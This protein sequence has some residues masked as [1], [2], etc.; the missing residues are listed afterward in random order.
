[1]PLGTDTETIIIKPLS[2]L[3]TGAIFSEEIVVSFQLSYNATGGTFTITVLKDTVVLPPENAV[4]SMPF[5]RVGIVKN[6]GGGLSTGG[7]VD[8]ISGPILPLSATLVNFVGIPNGTNQ[9]AATLAAQL[10]G[11]SGVFWET[12]VPFVKNF[13]YRGISLPG[14]QQLAQIVLAD[15]IVRK[16]GIH[17]VDPG[18]VIGNTPFNVQKSDIVSASQVLDFSQDIASVL[19]PALVTVIINDQGD[20]VYDSQ[21]AQKQPKF[22]VQAGSPQSQAAKDFIPIPDGWLVDGNFE[23]WTPPSSTDFSNPSASVPAGR[24]WKVY[25][26]PV[27]PAA[28]RGITNFTRL[29]KEVKLPGNVSSFI[30]SPITGLTRKNTTLEFIF[31]NK[32]TESGI[33]GFNADETTMFD[34]ISHQF[35]TFD[36]ALVLRPNSGVDSSDASSNF[37]SITMEQWTFPR[38][39]PQIFPVGDPVNPFGLPTNVVV[40]TPSS[41]VIA[42]DLGS[43]HQKYLSNYRLINSPRLRTT[44]SVV[45]R[46]FMPQVG[47]RLIVL[48]GLRVNDCGRIQSVSLNFGRAGIVLSITA[49]RY[50]YGS[51]LFSQGFGGS[52]VS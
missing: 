31:D 33:F 41:N 29:I 51:G 49:E 27:N 39:S 21:H 18:A 42:P 24:Y 23:E 14:I 34:I 28:L 13:V 15:V 52:V 26:S 38:V 2:A 11:G 46:N 25:Q 44:I 37:Y 12:F 43:Y 9:D 17:V 40:V 6:T 47:D 10:A 19:N 22:T 45:Y 20:F 30:G 7:L 32:G 50:Q 16:D 35:F 8:T 48:S 36:H 5:G 1:M 3:G 4:L